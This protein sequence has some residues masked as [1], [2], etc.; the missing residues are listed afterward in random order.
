MRTQIIIYTCIHTHI[1][2]NTDINNTHISVT[3]ISDEGFLILKHD[4]DGRDLELDYAERVVGQINT[5]WPAGVK[6]FTVI[7]EEVWEI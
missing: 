2:T 1:D 7:E 4:H 5:L 6:L 3:D